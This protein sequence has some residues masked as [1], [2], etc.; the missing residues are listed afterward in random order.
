MK[1]IGGKVAADWSLKTKKR[2]FLHFNWE[3]SK[4]FFLLHWH[5]RS[6]CLNARLYV[7]VCFMLPVDA[8]NHYQWH[9]PIYV[10]CINL[11]IFNKRLSVQSWTSFGKRCAFFLNRF[12][13][14]CF[15][16]I[17]QRTITE[18]ERERERGSL[19]ALQLCYSHEICHF[20]Y[21]GWWRKTSRYSTSIINGSITCSWTAKKSGIVRFP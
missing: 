2:F 19:H 17:D 15:L 20:S 12:C 9:P 6:S 1:F 14:C 11:G 3:K 13:N 10:L 4:N 16:L 7:S 18:R 21:T 5:K 8:Y